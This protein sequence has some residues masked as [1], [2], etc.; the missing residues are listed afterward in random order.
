MN[1]FHKAKVHLI[2]SDQHLITHLLAIA[3]V[4]FLFYDWRLTLLCLVLIQVFAL[5]GHSFFEKSKPI[6]RK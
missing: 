6:F 3:A 2:G 4:V 5:A 1:Y